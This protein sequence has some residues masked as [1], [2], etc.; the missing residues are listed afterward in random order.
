MVK[1]TYTKRTENKILKEYYRKELRPDE[2][3]IMNE[4]K[5]ISKRFKIPFSIVNRIINNSF[6]KS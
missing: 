5:D 2:E 3:V 1:K 4:V 6:K